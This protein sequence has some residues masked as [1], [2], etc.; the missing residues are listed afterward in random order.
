MKEINESGEIQFYKPA[1]R[2]WIPFLVADVLLIAVIVVMLN[3]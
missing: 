3:D 2:L 1:K